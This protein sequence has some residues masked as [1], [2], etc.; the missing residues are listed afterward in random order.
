[1]VFD[2]MWQTEFWEVI[3]HALPGMIK[4]VGYLSPRVMFGLPIIV[5]KPSSTLSKSWKL[6]RQIWLGNCFVRRHFDQS[7]RDVVPRS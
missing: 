2:D 1:M 5:K 7:L 4:P 6:G 3:R